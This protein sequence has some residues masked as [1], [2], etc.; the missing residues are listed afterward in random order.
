MDLPRPA[1][2]RAVPPAGDGDTDDG[3]HVEG[4]VPTWEEVARDHSRFIY[5]V[6]YRLSGRHD[7]AEDLVQE[8]LIRV[9]RGLVTYEP[10]SLTGW[11]ARITTNVFLDGVR[12]RSRQPT[13]HLGDDADRM[14]PAS[15]TAEADLAATTLPDDIQQAIR[16]L[17]PDFRA[18]VVLSDVV[19]LTYPEIAETVGVPI[20]TV[21]SR[22]H[23][24]RLLLRDSLAHRREDQ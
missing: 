15:P 4:H 19:G 17:P 18:A 1:P 23:R 2:L 22:I 11:L 13:D 8:V 24:G 6:A 14:L 3:I 9:R 7:E 12:K 5:S 20:G 10:R 16:A 21:R